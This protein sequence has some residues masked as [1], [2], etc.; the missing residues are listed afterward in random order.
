MSLD[1][2]GRVPMLDALEA[3]TE[4]Q[5][6]LQCSLAF[7]VCLINL[8]ELFELCERSLDLRA[9]EMLARR[10]TRGSCGDR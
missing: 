1:K 2:M 3:P 4:M 8:N 9:V 10:E 7:E 5:S 6:K